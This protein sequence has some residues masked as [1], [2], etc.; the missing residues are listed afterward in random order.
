[1]RGGGLVNEGRRAS[2]VPWLAMFPRLAVF[3][4]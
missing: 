3:L 4:G 2:C 1:M